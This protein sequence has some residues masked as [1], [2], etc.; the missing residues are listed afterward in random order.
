MRLRRE[1]IVRAAL[2]LVDQVGLEGLTL[3]LIADELGVRAPALYWHVKNKQE[4]L[5]EMATVVLGDLYHQVRPQRP[6]ETWVEWMA[7][8]A[9]KLR[10]T[11]LSYRDGARMCAGTYVADPRLVE[12]E[13][14]W[15][16]VLIDAGFSVQDAVGGGWTVYNFVI[17]HT[18]EEQAVAPRPG[19]LNEQYSQERLQEHHNPDRYPLAAEASRYTF[20]PDSAEE[21]FEHGLRLILT[22]MRLSLLGQHNAH[23]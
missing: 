2:K 5:D 20:D 8:F 14:I 3:R 19:E 6:G 1:A 22:G 15:L 21:R 18:I 23:A 13:E 10:R 11:L 4:L 17:G 12:A 7:D 16:R 9:R